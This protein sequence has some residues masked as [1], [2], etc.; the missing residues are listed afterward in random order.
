[1]SRDSGTRDTVAPALWS[2]SVVKIGFQVDF[3]Q[4]AALCGP[5]YVFFCRLI[6]A[7]I[8]N[9][10]NHVFGPRQLR[11]VSEVATAMRSTTAAQWRPLLLALI[12]AGVAAPPARAEA[13]GTCPVRRDPQPEE[14]FA[15]P[16]KPSFVETSCYAAV[17]DTSPSYKPWA[18]RPFC[19]RATVG[20]DP[21][22][23]VCAFTYRYPPTSP[24]HGSPQ[25]RP[26]KAEPG[27][28]PHPPHHPT[29][30]LMTTPANAARIVDLAIFEDQL[31]GPPEA[32]FMPFDEARK[33]WAAGKKWKVVDM[34]ALKDSA[35]G[36]KGKG[37]AEKGSKVKSKGMGVVATR[38]I[39]RWETILVDRAVVFGDTV[40][41][42]NL[43][44][45]DGYRLL[46]TAVRR[47][48]DPKVVT[49]L[50]K[51]GIDKND[52][53]QDVIVTNSFHTEVASADG[54][55]LYPRVS[56]SKAGLACVLW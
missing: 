29:L 28:E 38:R 35:A 17:D 50:A 46:N 55:G 24:R 5:Q 34:D 44:Q 33:Y 4:L 56:V 1:M 42:G 39:Q 21:N 37:G 25:K 36:S 31:S 23:K 20:T 40:A 18:Q 22:L 8:W 6:Q 3:R 30:S 11:L 10:L 27:W 15:P 48:A 26:A 16:P 7:V 43:I 49:D 9:H 53:V 41:N 14:M 47:L 51:S 12:L 2:G 45:Q 32:A 13:A 54:S 52:A 19:V